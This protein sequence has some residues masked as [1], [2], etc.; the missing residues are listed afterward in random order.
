MMK[1]KYR[2]EKIKGKIQG[3]T[4]VA[5]LFRGVKSNLLQWCDET[6]QGLLGALLDS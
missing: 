5:I 3:V 1:M 4:P 6:E 2:K